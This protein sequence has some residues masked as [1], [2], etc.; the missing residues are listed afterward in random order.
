MD[1]DTADTDAERD[2]KDTER[3]PSVTPDSDIE[4]RMVVGP[5]EPAKHRHSHSHAH[6]LAVVEAVDDKSLECCCASVVVVLCLVR[7]SCHD[8]HHHFPSS[9]ACSSSCSSSRGSCILALVHHH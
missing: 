4:H 3:L 5:V 8:E 6:N 7:Y 9:Q 1:A 2:E